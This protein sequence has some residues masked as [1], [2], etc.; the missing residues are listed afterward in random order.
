MQFE[1]GL[2]MRSVE[3]NGAGKSTLMKIIMGLY[4]A[5][6]GQIYI[7]EKPV[8]IKN[9][10]QAQQYGISMIAQELNYVPELSVAE[11][12]F[13]GRLPVNKFG[14]VNWRK[15]K[16]DAVQFLKEQGLGVFAES[17]AEDADGFRDSDA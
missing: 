2:C 3:E 15:V 10:I 14:K 4:K 17:K 13:L 8:D 9:P 7:D 1:K 12:L 16:K 5:D 11:N 6:K